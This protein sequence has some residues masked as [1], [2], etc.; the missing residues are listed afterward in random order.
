LSHLTDLDPSLSVAPL[1]V[2]GAVLR[3]VEAGAGVWEGRRLLDQLDDE[4][5][6]PVVDDAI[7][8]RADKSLEHVFTLLALVMPRQ[9][10]RIAFRALYVNDMFLRGTALE[11]LEGALPPEIRKPLWP[12]LEDRRPRRPPSVRPTEETLAQLLRSSESIVIQLDELR[13]KGPG[14]SPPPG[15]PR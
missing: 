13:R 3:E 8:E 2:Y 7:R 11:Y 10:L 14:A 6:S 1:I 4:P 9:P 15:P 12:H 5:W